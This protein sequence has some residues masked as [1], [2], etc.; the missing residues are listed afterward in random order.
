MH[1]QYLWEGREVCWRDFFVSADMLHV[2]GSLFMF[3]H[4]NRFVNTRHDPDCTAGGIS[5]STTRQGG[6]NVGYNI[7]STEGK[8]TDLDGANVRH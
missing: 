1:S 8:I 2:C 5:F 4:R 6:G 7:A 3:V